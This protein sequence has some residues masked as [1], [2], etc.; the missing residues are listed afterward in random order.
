MSDIAANMKAMCKLLEGDGHMTPIATR[1]ILSVV[2]R[3]ETTPRTVTTV[4]E[5]DALPAR[6]LIREYDGFRRLKEING[7]W[8]LCIQSGGI[9]ESDEIVLP[10]TILYVPE[11]PSD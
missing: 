5:L 9:G 3:W 8:L 2:E 4:E 11:V 6:T 1:Q 10:A 7:M